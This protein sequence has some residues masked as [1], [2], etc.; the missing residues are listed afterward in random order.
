MWSHSNTHGDV[1]SAA[2]EEAERFCRQQR[3][4]SGTKMI[5]HLHGLWVWLVSIS[6]S[7]FSTKTS[8]RHVL[9]K[10]ALVGHTSR[11]KSVGIYHDIQRVSL[12]PIPLFTLT[13]QT[14][15]PHPTPTTRFV[16]FN[17]LFCFVR[18]WAR[19]FMEKT[20]WLSI[21]YHTIY[22]V[23]NT[24]KSVNI[25]DVNMIFVIET[26]CPTKTVPLNE[27]Q[28]DYAAR[29]FGCVEDLTS[30]SETGEKS[31]H[32]QIWQLVRAILSRNMWGVINGPF[33][34]LAVSSAPKSSALIHWLKVLDLH[35]PIYGTKF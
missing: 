15:Y 13:L 21:A 34:S 26:N 35:V 16:Q 6:Y 3:R 27:R 28:A 4:A 7:R 33:K 19:R 32:C 25:G 18:L 29:A 11:C 20:R 8:L 22:S 17:C 30:P 10:F 24:Y 9:L 14:G 12:Q 2:G 31:L 1:I 23:H 5:D